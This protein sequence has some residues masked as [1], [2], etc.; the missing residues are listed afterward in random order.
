MVAW[1]AFRMLLYA[2]ASRNTTLHSSNYWGCNFAAPDPYSR[3]EE[4]GKDTQ[5]EP[6]NP[7]ACVRETIPP[8][9][10]HNGY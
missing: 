4:V 2:Y 10:Y 6:S 3:P 5:F 7:V 1:L 9:Q 8:P